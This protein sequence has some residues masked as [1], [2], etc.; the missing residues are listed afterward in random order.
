MLRGVDSDEPVNTQ[1]SGRCGVGLEF[2]AAWRRIRRAL[3]L[4][5]GSFA[6]VSGSARFARWR[7]Q[8]GSRQR[9]P[10]HLSRS[11]MG[12][13]GHFEN[14]LHVRLRE[15]HRHANVS[16][17]RGAWETLGARRG[18]VV[19]GKRWARRTRGR[20]PIISLFYQA[21][22]YRAQPAPESPPRRAATRRISHQFH[23]P[24]G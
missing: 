18:R 21:E 23:R 1:I 19:R 5:R 15:P 22:W 8:R 2:G 24:L 16:L 20:R 12:R 13:A 10:P 17:R 11:G 6:P 7:N 14:S 9:S 4:S 3:R